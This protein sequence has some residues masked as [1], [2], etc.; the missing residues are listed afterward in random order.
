[1]RESAAGTKALLMQGWSYS[2][3]EAGRVFEI[4]RADH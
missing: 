2:G 3:R 4:R 1:L